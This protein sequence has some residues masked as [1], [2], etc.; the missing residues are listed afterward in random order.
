MRPPFCRVGSKKSISK[1]IINMIPP[2]EIYV[3]PFVG[4]GAIYWDKQPSKKE[5]IN[6]IDK[7]LIN[8]YKLLKRTKDR[9]FRTDLNTIDK[10]QN[11]V[12]EVHRTEGGRLMKAISI[13]CGTFVTGSGKGGIYRKSN[14]YNKLKNIDEYQKRMDNTTILN[15]DYKT[16]IKKYDSPQTFFFLDPPYESSEKLYKKGSFDFEELNKVLKGVKGKFILTL[17]DSRNIRNI[18]NS[19]KISGITVASKGNKGIGVKDRKE[20]IIKN[21]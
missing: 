21:Y 1:K 19:F 16:V 5:I 12:N 8:N 17:N 7:D 18:F 15:Q 6:D 3:E 9:N 10:V 14:P 4:S 13:S 20:L 2:H 11:F